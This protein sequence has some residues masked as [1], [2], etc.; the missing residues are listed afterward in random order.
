MILKGLID[1]DGTKGKELVF[2]S[3][4]YNL[5]VRKIYMSKWEYFS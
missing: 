2:D 4:S 1:T 3:T 5:I